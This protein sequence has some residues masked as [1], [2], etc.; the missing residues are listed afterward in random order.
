M[1]NEA[2]CI[3]FRFRGEEVTTLGRHTKIFTCLRKVKSVAS[4]TLIQCK[5][6]KETNMAIISRRVAT[7]LPGKTA[8]T[9]SRAK[10]LAEIMVRAGGGAR[11]R[12]VIFGDGAGDIHLYG[13]FSDF[14]SGT[15]SAAAMNKDPQMA[16]WQAEREAEPSSHLRG[17]EVYRTAFGE[18]SMKPV[19]LQRT[20]SIDRANVQNALALMPELQGIVGETPLM[21]VLPT[22]ASVMDEML[23]VYYFDSLEHFG[24]QLDEVAMSPEFQKLVTKASAYGTLKSSRLLAAVD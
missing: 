17:P 12:K 9:I 22:I 13:S 15:K 11:V 14:T 6:K 19:I 4:K 5:S 3:L 2:F 8:L 7:P 23:I 21:A 1:M 20:Y 10:T 18:P 24:V 16:K